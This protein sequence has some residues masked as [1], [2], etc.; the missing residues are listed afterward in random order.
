MVRFGLYLGLVRQPAKQTAAGDEDEY[1]CYKMAKERRTGLKKA[2][3][4][5]PSSPADILDVDLVEADR[6]LGEATAE[7]RAAGLDFY[8]PYNRQA[9]LSE[10]A[11]AKPRAGVAGR[12]PTQPSY[13]PPKTNEPGTASTAVLRPP[14]PPLAANRP[15]P[16]ATPAVLRAP[17]VKPKGPTPAEAHGAPAEP[18]VLPRQKTM[19]KRRTVESPAS[20]GRTDHGA[21]DDEEQMELELIRLRQQELQMMM[22]RRAGGPRT[23]HHWPWDP[24]KFGCF[25]GF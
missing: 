9:P 1:A 7:M 17:P 16:K 25:A 3:W 22:R 24:G 4:P 8:T 19:P 14:P 13:P 11:K 23:Y 21:E 20:S 6:L 12:T 10:A 2:D 5:K 15:I 18:P